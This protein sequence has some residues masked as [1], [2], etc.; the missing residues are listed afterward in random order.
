MKWR[1]A[2]ALAG[3]FA[4]A[5]CCPD[6][7]VQAAGPLRCGRFTEDVP[8]APEP[9]E[10]AHAHARFEQINAAAKTQPYQVLFF[11]DSLTERFDREIWEQH[12]TPRS[13]LNA[14]V[15]GDRSENLL[16]RLEHG[17]LDGPPPRAAILLIGTNDLGR[18]RSPEVAAEGVRSNLLKLRQHLPETE[19]LL[20]GLWPR[21]DVPRIVQ[22]HE[23]AA[24]NALIAT[25]GDGI[26]IHYADLGRL[27]LDADGRLAPGISADHLHFNSQG[28]ARL[29]PSL[30]REIDQLVRRH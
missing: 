4:I 27:L 28:Y 7:P 6:A 14:G 15:S 21:E 20:L 12:M 30:D 25:C 10:N 17:N 3:L 24:V 23:I 13:V 22:R 19:V 2:I 16:W 9:R 1:T 29:A 11:G 26:R 8:P 18:E 5:V